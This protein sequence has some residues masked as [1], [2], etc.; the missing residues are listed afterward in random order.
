MKGF[1]NGLLVG[2]LIGGVAALLLAPRK[3]T[4]TREMLKE[5]IDRVKAEIERRK[6]ELEEM[7]AQ[8]KASTQNTEV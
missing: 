2:A 4:E 3:G 7:E 1:M 6:K 5:K 8:M